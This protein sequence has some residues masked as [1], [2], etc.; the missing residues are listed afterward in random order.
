MMIFLPNGNCIIYLMKDSEN[1]RLPGDYFISLLF[2]V[3]LSKI[4][5]PC[6]QLRMNIETLWMTFNVGDVST[7]R[8][9]LLV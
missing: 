5:P 7:N 6:I 4:E 8:R 2:G 3:D 9:Y 1:N